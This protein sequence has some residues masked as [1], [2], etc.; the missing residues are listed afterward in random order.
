MHILVCE[1]QDSIRH[2]LEV[3]IRAR[4]FRA[5]TVA[6]GG[7][8]IQVAAAAPP[9]VVLL[10]LML[11]GDYDGLEVCRRLRLAPTTRNVPILVVSALDDDEWRRK[12]SKAG[13]TAYYLKP[14]SPTAL[15]REIARL[16][17]PSTRPQ[18]SLH[19]KGSARDSGAST[20]S[21]PAGPRSFAPAHRPSTT[22]P[23]SGT[24]PR[25]PTSGKPPGG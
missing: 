2:M 23:P 21:A 20:S 3:L 12:A 10:D 7:Q 8:A 17:P 1:D 5:T 24:T 25:K 14:F 22:A 19:P 13:A 9:D 11:P 6:T 18:A 16:R 15:L 4:G